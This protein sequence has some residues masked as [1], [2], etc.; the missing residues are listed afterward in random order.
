MIP[1]K[2][3]ITDTFAQFFYVSYVL[4][5]CYNRLGEAILTNIRNV[6]FH[7]QLHGAAN[8]KIND[9]L[10]FMQIELTL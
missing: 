8:E 6:C 5:I 7:K 4:C 3:Q 1:S 10:I 9:P 2:T